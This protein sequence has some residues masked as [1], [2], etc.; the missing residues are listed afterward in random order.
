L[1]TVHG[2][3]RQHGGWITVQSEVGR[4]T[5]FRVLL[6]ALP[7]A[8]TE[9]P[10]A[11]PTD[12]S[13]GSVE[14]ILVVEDEAALRSLVCTVLRRQGFRVLEADSGAAA[15]ELWRRHRDQIDL[16]LTDVMM[17][18]GMSGK[19]LALRLLADMPKLKVIYNSAYTTE[20]FD[21]GI[22]VIE[23][24]NYL[25]KPFSLTLLVETVRAALNR[26]E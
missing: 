22:E 10:P 16:L 9:T 17:P 3:A 11:A 15:L 12:R 8:R 25:Q 2:I 26:K 13:S 7:P 23:G 19:E 5:T 14:T 18:G 24:T 21:Q 4:G 6:P 1:A 20:F